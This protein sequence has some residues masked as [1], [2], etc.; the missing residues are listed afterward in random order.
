MSS[1]ATQS[2]GPFRKEAPSRACVLACLG[3]K[4]VYPQWNLRHGACP[5]HNTQLS[6]HPGTLAAVEA[7]K[8]GRLQTVRPRCSALLAVC[9][10]QDRAKQD[11]ICTSMLRDWVEGLGSKGLQHAVQCVE[12]WE[13]SNVTCSMRSSHGQSACHL[14]CAY[15]DNRPLLAEPLPAIRALHTAAQPVW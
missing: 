3:I 11:G 5:Q 4:S 15:A 9:A 6:A 13:R 2:V 1:T 10:L 8:T 7:E 12:N 14:L